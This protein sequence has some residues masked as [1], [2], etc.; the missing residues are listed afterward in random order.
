MEDRVD[1]FCVMIYERLNLPFNASLDD[2]IEQLPKHPLYLTS[3]VRNFLQL[4]S[5]DETK[6]WITWAIEYQCDV[7]LVKYLLSIDTSLENFAFGVALYNMFTGGSKYYSRPC[8]TREKCMNTLNGLMLLP[9]PLTK[10]DMNFVMGRI[11][12]FEEDVL[13]ALTRHP[14]FDVKWTD[15]FKCQSVFHYACEKGF[16]KLVQHFVEKFNVDVNQPTNDRM[17]YSPLA[18]AAGSTG[19]TYKAWSTVDYLLNRGARLFANSP[20]NE[21]HHVDSWTLRYIQARL[22]SFQLIRDFSYLPNDILRT[23]METMYKT[24]PITDLRES[25]KRLLEDF[26]YFGNRREYMTRVYILLD[27]LPDAPL[28]DQRTTLFELENETHYLKICVDG[29]GIQ[30]NEYWSLAFL[31]VCYQRYHFNITKI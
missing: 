17:E 26:N 8:H 27:G 14:S 1:A 21:Y 2:L 18:L 12:T 29:G 6:S 31:S 13:I 16:T 24:P 23:V 19:R 25:A 11:G 4:L 10:H 20:Y 15:Y 5:I 7:P 9:L 28:V 30:P 22:I 3:E